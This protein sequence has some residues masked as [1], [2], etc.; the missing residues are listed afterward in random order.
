VSKAKEIQKADAQT[1][2]KKS[3]PNKACEKCS[4]PFYAAPSH[5]AKGQGRFCSLTCARS[6]KENPRY[7]E[8]NIQCPR[9][10]KAFHVKPSGH[11][12]G[13][14][15]KYCSD[16]CRLAV[17]TAEV[18]CRTCSKSF[19]VPASHGHRRVF[20]SEE[21]MKKS[22]KNSLPN[23]ACVTCKKPFYIKESDLKR[24]RGAGAFCSAKC[25]TGSRGKIRLE[26]GKFASHLERDLYLL[27]KGEG[28]T[29]GLDRE[30]KFHPT[31][32]WRLDFAWPDVK[33]AVEVHGGIWLPDR[34]GHTSGSGRMRDMEKLNE[35]TMHGWLV[36]EVA[37]NHI[38]SGEAIEWIKRLFLKRAMA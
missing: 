37:S 24:G 8:L 27:M 11:A 30:H 20:C 14:A 10:D 12:A 4:A 33:I 25:M 21:C 15:R 1:K 35:A 32:R 38:R 16:E 34:G 18:A 5:V 17:Q 19:S 26:D 6:G 22:F 7:K 13:K 9:C 23:R 31:R 28:M 29:E 3:N 36:L 2:R